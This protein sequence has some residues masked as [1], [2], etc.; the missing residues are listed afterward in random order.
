VVAAAGWL[1]KV[2][3]EAMAHFMYQSAQDVFVGA[4]TKGVRVQGQLVGESSGIGA[5]G[6]AV[7]DKV[8]AAADFTLESDET[9]RQVAAKEL[10]IEPLVGPCQRRCIRGR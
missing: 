1:A 7:I 2:L 5:V 4:V 3:L 6:K 9:R 8:A 10:L